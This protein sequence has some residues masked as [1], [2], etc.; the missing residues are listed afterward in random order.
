MRRHGCIVT[1]IVPLRTPGR[2]RAQAALLL[3]LA[4]PAA[5]SAAAGW[6][7]SVGLLS[8]K[9]VYGLSQ[10]AGDP[11]AVLDLAWRD[12]SGWSLA[13][14]L[15]TLGAGAQ[16]PDA[17]LSLGGGLGGPLDETSAWQLSY[18]RFEITGRAGTRRPGYDQLTLGYGWQEQLQLTLVYTGGFSA[19]A[20][21]GGRVRANGLIAE[22]T[23]HQGLGR[24]WAL[25]VGLGRVHYP[26]SSLRDFSYGSL[27][28]SWG[29]GPVQF[30]ASRVFSNS[31]ASTAVGRKA[32][33]SVL[34][35]F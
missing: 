20:P 21:G 9:V 23:W 31:R 7:G 35:G 34:W 2:L 11:S 10:S 27:G 32:V 1:R 13:A 15:A 14:G 6:S 4:A 5:T 17:E 18:T 25:D 33:V 19:P 16:R 12:A 3:A 29:L 28:L 22:A 24:R 26:E 8:D 30:F